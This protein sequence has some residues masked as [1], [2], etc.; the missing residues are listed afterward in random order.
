[1][2]L[3]HIRDLVD[4]IYVKKAFDS[5][6]LI[7]ENFLQKIPKLGKFPGTNPKI[8][9]FSQKKIQNLELTSEI[10]LETY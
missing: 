6:K 8:A 4:S 1:M 2:V 5:A 3:N 7:S 10:V 9:K